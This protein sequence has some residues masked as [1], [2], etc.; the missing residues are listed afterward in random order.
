M[1]TQMQTPVR[2]D[3]VFLLGRPPVSGFVRL[4]RTLT[5]SGSRVDEEDL[6]REWRQAHDHVR[7]LELAEAGLADQPD[8]RPI[9]EHMKLLAEVEMARQAIKQSLRFTRYDWSLVELDRTVVF[10]KSINLGFVRELSVTL[11]EFPTDDDSFRLS[12]GQGRQLPPVHM[13]RLPDSTY[14]FSSASADVRVLEVTPLD[15]SLVQGYP[16]AGYPSALIGVF[17]GFGINVIS[18]IHARNRVILT[19]GS[20]RA[21]ALR[22]RGVT[23]IPCL[24]SKVTRDDELDLIAPPEVKKD[25]DLYLKAPRP[26]LFKDYFNP[27]LGKVVQVHRNNRLLQVHVTC[28]QLASAAL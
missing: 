8:L 9:P 12:L 1:S 26:P 10:Q 13:I 6:A 24:V 27:R 4:I 18:G 14:L 3:F 22:A 21:Y 15:P 23:H 19:N 28:Q 11:P 20:H 5:V 2:D 16:I 25:L 17:V 7:E